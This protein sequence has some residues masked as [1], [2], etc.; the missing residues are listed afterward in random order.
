MKAHTAVRFDPSHLSIHL[1]KFPSADLLWSDPDD[2][3]STWAL[4]P[5]GCGFLFGARVAQQFT[6][7]NNL[8]LIARAHQLVEEGWQY[9]FGER[10]ITNCAVIVPILILFFRFRLVTV[11][12]APNYCYRCGN[13]AAI[14]RLG[15]RGEREMTVYGPAAENDTDSRMRERRQVRIQSVGMHE[16]ELTNYVDDLPGERRRHAIFC[17]TL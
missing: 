6:H 3:V 7:L 5:R 8:S 16:I 9:K 1:D 14:L 2:A 11:W 13:E 15:E 12:S 4:S 10:Y 17:V